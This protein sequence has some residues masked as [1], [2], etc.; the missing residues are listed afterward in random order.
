MLL[1][2][3]RGQRTRRVR[4]VPGG[5]TCSERWP[6]PPLVLRRELE[7]SDE[8]HGSRVLPGVDVSIS[9]AIRKARE[10][11]NLS[12]AG[13]AAR[14]GLSPNEYFD[15][16]NHDDEAVDVVHLREVKKVAGVLHLDLLGLFGI[17]CMVCEHPEPP[18]PDPHVT[19]NELVR[20]TREAM[21]LSQDD[22]GDRVGFET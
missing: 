7:R 13:V 21:G 19:R 8:V 5:P 2:G 14:T 1:G 17:R 9:E 16:E 15:L 4:N 11:L 3:R 10:R 20:R 12:E 18:T 6:C 22:L